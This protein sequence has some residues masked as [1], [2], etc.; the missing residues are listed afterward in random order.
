MLLSPQ[1]HRLASLHE[2]GIVILTVRAKSWPSSDPNDVTSWS[3]ANIRS[4]SPMKNS[5]N[6]LSR[7]FTEK[8]GNPL[9]K[10]WQLNLGKSDS[11]SNAKRLLDRTLYPDGC[12][13]QL[14][15]ILRKVLQDVKSVVVSQSRQ[16]FC[17][18]N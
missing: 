3:S 17:I 11:L 14:D 15:H 5:V 6:M 12:A 13:P 7:Q 4:S 18:M 9:I 10:V 16:H 1:A 2:C 8:I